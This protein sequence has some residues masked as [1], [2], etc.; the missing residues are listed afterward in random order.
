M[1]ENEG[2]IKVVE[3]MFL[4]SPIIKPLGEYASKLF[5]KVIKEKD[6][7]LFSEFIVRELKKIIDKNQK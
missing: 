6:I 2:I 5:A 3:I 1:K 4:I 7:L